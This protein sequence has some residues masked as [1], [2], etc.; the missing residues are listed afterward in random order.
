MAGTASTVRSWLLLEDAG[1]WAATR[2]GMHGCPS[3]SGSSSSAVPS[4]GRPPA[5]DPPRVAGRHP[6]QDLTCFAIRSGPEPPWIERASLAN[7]RDA[8]PR[9]ARPRRRDPARV[10]GG[11][12]SA[13][14][15]VHARATRCLLRRA[16]A[17]RAR[18]RRRLPDRTWESSH[19][20]GDR[21]A[22]NLVAFPH[23]LYLGRVG[24]DEAADVARSYVDGKVSLEHLRGRSCS[25]CPSRRPTTRSDTRGVRPPRRC[26]ARANRGARGGVHLDVHHAEGAILGLHRDRG[27]E[28]A[29]LTCHSH[30]EE[31]APVPGDLGRTIAAMSELT[32]VLSAIESLSARGRKLALATIVAVSGSTYRRPGARLLVPEEGE[33]VGNIS[34]GCLENDVADVAKIVM[35]EASR[36]SSRSTSPPTTTRSGAGDS[37]ATVRSSCS[38]SRPTRP[39][40]WPAHSAWPS[41][42]SDRSRW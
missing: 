25:A 3:G 5:P 8:R 24:S 22:G 30:V 34:G 32:D 2:S 16:R 36:A 4:R 17:A 33:L 12:G 31:P 40:R 10:R 9:P 1:P 26:G 41:R 20:G 35:R 27:L 7:V 19:V 11:R 18:A 28:P 37:D 38:S 14:P 39:P 42:R 13:L 23:G 6:S 21:F 29:F 15:R